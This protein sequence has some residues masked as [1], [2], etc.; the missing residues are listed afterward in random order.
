MLA[1]APFRQSPSPSKQVSEQPN[2][3]LVSK[4]GWG[5][6]QLVSSRAD[7]ESPKEDAHRYGV[8][9]WASGLWYIG[10][11]VIAWLGLIQD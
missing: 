3:G 7:S 4:P 2:E 1:S 8:V 10:D 5:W 9:S 6:Q 11:R